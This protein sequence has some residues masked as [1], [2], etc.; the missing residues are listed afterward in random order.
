M[1][2]KLVYDDLRENRKILRKTEEILKRLRGLK[3]NTSS[4]QDTAKSISLLN[5]F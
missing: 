5:D 2:A 1:K 3:R 4:L